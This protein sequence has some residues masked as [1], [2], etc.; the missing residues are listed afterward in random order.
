[1]KR[2]SEQ[3][4][5]RWIIQEQTRWLEQ[6]KDPLLDHTGSIESNRKASRAWL[7]S[8][9]F[10][11]VDRAELGT[12][13]TNGQEKA[14]EFAQVN[15]AGQALEAIVSASYGK[16]DPVFRATRCAFQRGSIGSVPKV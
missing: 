4:A 13:R 9:P 16:V 12:D 8:R 6:H 11:P 14:E 7:R 1:M 2:S 5:R 3:R 15:E 10:N